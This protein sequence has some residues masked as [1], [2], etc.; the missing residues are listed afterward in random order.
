M[1]SLTKLTLVLLAMTFSGAVFAASENP[2]CGYW[3]KHLVEVN[4]RLEE[5]QQNLTLCQ[6]NRSDC[7]D[8]ELLVQ[9][10]ETEKSTTEQF[11][12]DFCQK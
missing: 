7:R 3:Q 1:K 4:Q 10:L 12:K 9:S 8:T 5:A 2:E 6:A 11:L